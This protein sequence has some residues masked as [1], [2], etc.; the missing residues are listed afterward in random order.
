M[1]R[2]RPAGT[3]RVRLAVCLALALGSAPSLAAQ[4]INLL[5]PLDS[6][7]ERARR[8]SL[9][10]PVL[11]DAALGAWVY[12]KWELA[13]SLL[14]RAVRVDP[15][16]APAHLALA[17]LP[18]AQRQ[19]L[20][21]EEDRGKI[22]AEWRERLER[23]YYHYRRAFLIDPMVDL[24]VIGLA[25][26]PRGA[27]TIGGSVDRYYAN[28]IL[29]VEQFWGGNYP[30]AFDLLDRVVQQTPPDRRAKELPSY[31]LW[32]HGLAGAHLDRYDIAIGNFQM[33]LDRRLEQRR[34]KADSVTSA[35]QLR[36][37][38]LR[39]VL[40]TLKHKSGSLAEATR[41]LQEVLEVDLSFDMAHAQLADI[42]ERHR[43][44]EDAIAE[45]RRAIETN[46]DDPSLLFDLG[47]TLAK[48]RRLRE[49]IEALERASTANPLNARIPYTLSEMQVFV[50]DTTAAVASLRKFA[51]IASSR[52]EPQL[53][54]A[55][56]KYG[57]LR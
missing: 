15:R 53:K 41:L 7:M 46:P 40:A 23:S 17:Y 52:F 49:A 24:K 47:M 36:E 16:F 11:Y 38:D 51:R 42:H 57:S 8:D 37:N 34:T 5:V 32:L 2:R 10:A 29:G 18:F 33:L 26:P 50:G 45:R 35:T 6:L 27:L 54:A 43:R 1:T 25:V 44:W 28:I 3:L 55:E 31:L 19:K 56:A 22:P 9:D 39:Y 30:A 21:D 12:R 14:Q 20:W 4:R 13:D 48:A